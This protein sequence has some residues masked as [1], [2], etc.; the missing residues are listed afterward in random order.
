MI[1]NVALQPADRLLALEVRSRKIGFAVFEGPGRLLDWGVRSCSHPTRELPEVVAKRVRPLLVR[2]EPIALAVRNENQYSSQTAVRLRAS[3]TSIR[4]EA[5]Q[6]G[7]EFQ[8]LKTRT[9]KHFLV[10]RGYCTKYQVAEMIGKSFEEF[11]WKVQPQRK[12]WHSESYHTIIFDAVATGLVVLAEK[13]DS[14][15]ID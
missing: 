4:K 9:R 7:V 10:Q 1:E 13:F 11:S 12:A 2:Y 3:I 15:T 14:M 5:T 8:L 6:C